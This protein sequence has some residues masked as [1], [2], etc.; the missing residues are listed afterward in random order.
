MFFDIHASTMIGW[1]SGRACPAQ[2]VVKALLG[3]LVFQRTGIAHQEMGASIY[4]S[5]V[6]SSR[7]PAPKHIFRTSSTTIS[8]PIAVAPTSITITTIW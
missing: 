6:N 1:L 8:E 7:A 2:T 3:G 5:G 4:D